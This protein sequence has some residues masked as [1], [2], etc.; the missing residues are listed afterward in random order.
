MVAGVFNTSSAP[1]Q[2]V[3]GQLNSVNSAINQDSLGAEEEHQFIV[4]AGK[5]ENNRADSFIVTPERTIVSS[6]LKVTGD[7]PPSVTDPDGPFTNGTAIIL[8]NL[9]L[10]DPGVAGQLYADPLNGF[11]LKVSQG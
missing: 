3:V 6:S 5:D 1:N 4:G 11:T 2:F 8:E 10:S 9:P 7:V